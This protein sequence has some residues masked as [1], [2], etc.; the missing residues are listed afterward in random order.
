MPALKQR[1]FNE[2]TAM[3]TPINFADLEPARHPRANAGRLVCPPPTG[4]ATG[5]RQEA[6]ASGTQRKNGY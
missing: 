6:G 1:L 4:G 5:A 2:R 3:Q